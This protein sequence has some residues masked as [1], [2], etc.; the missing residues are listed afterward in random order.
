MVAEAESNSVNEVMSL[1]WEPTPSP[2]Y[3]GDLVLL[4]L[5]EYIISEI[6]DFVKFYQGTLEMYQ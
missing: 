2:P 6:L 1:I 4:S 3:R 5:S